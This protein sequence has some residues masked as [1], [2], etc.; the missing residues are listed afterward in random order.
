MAP[1]QRFWMAFFYSEMAMAISELT[2]Y[3]YRIKNI[4]FK[5]GFLIVL[6]TGITWAITVDNA[7]IGC[8]RW[9]LHWMSVEA[10]PTSSRHFIP[11]SRI[12]DVQKFQFDHGL[13][14]RFTRQFR[15][16]FSLHGCQVDVSPNPPWKG[17]ADAYSTGCTT[18]IFTRLETAVMISSDNWR[19]LQWFFWLRHNDISAC[20]MVQPVSLMCETDCLRRTMVI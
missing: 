14:A 16:V 15:H 10:F 17:W 6:V 12:S 18:N 3:F 11:N 20:T 2:G 5:W 13:I 8:P 4:L 7:L 9:T 1:L 19:L